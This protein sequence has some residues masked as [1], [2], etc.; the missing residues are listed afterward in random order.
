MKYLFCVG[1]FFFAFSFTEA[2]HTVVFKIKKNPQGHKGDHV[3][4]A[5]NFNGWN[6]HDSNYRFSPDW[7]NVL[8]LSFKLQAGDYEYKLTRGE[9]AKV[10]CRN[11]GK[12]IENRSVSILS[13]TTLE[14]NIDGWKDDFATAPREH[15]ASKQ[16]RVMDS[17]FFIPQLN[18]TRRIWIY[19]PEDYATS[20]K[21]YPVLYMHDGQNL[22][23]TYTSGFGEWGVD[24]WI[25]SLIK[26]GNQACI[27][28]G[29]DNGPQRFNEYN[30]YD[31]QQFGK[32]EGDK[33]IEFLAQTLKPFIDSKYRT[34]SSKENTL[35]AGSSMG[36]LISYYAMLKLPNVF[37][38]AGIFSPA[39]W[40]APAI[41]LFTDSIAGKIS[42]KFF[43]YMGGMEG[44]TYIKDMQEVQE[45]LGEKSASM[46]YSVIDPLSAHNEQAW[47]KWF[48]EFYVWIMADGFNTVI[49][50]KD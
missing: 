18:R 15:T 42:S 14:I 28:V 29:I 43:F 45:V 17:L 38:K 37:G 50:L 23:D 16:V 19:L 34:L 25:D 5:G 10:E 13:D 6:P 48:A 31:F 3:F 49:K 30:P 24:E 21:R 41:K 8:E 12:D 33:Y 27:V 22:F 20:K 47:R 11:G 1:I 9:W 40:T 32:G 35:I 36:G 26:K 4:I 2:Q 44:S 46:I 7:D 39:F